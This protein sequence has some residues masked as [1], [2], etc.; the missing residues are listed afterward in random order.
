MILKQ[1]INY[2][3]INSKIFNSFMSYLSRG[4]F[5]NGVELKPKD[6]KVLRV[7]QGEITMNKKDQSMLLTSLE[8]D[9]SDK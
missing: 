6:G 4:R 7:K 9:G 1:F 8:G 5:S 3:S 2:I